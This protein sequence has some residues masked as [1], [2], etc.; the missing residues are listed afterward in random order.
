MPIKL[1][2]ECKKLKHK[3]GKVY[4][5]SENKLAISLGT[6]PGPNSGPM[7]WDMGLPH[8]SI[9]IFFLPLLTLSTLA[10]L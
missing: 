1:G 8:L 2:S 4:R 10:T 6:K 3:M 9:C 7:E 5:I